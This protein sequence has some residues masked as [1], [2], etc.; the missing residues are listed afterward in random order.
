MAA[1]DS[2]G[3]QKLGRRQW[4]NN[5]QRFHVDG[6]LGEGLERLPDIENVTNS[7]QCASY[8]LARVAVA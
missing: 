2:I 5:R 7:L 8:Q 4:G 3:S 1:S 6:K